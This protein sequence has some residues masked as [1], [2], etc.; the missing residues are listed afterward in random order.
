MV[1]YYTA[2]Q[3]T[4]G[5]TSTLMVG[6]GDDSLENLFEETATY[7]NEPIFKE[8]IPEDVEHDFEIQRHFEKPRFHAD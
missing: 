8:E 3:S 5:T 7:D 1:P 6:S 2:T 4:D